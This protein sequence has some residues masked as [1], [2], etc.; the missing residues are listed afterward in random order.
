[1]GGA[2]SPGVLSRG[3]LDF[4]PLI[5]EFLVDGG[6]VIF[7]SV[8]WSG[9]LV[10]INHRVNF[11]GELLGLSEVIGTDI[12][13]GALGCEFW[14]FLG[15]FNSYFVVVGER[16]AMLNLFVDGFVDGDDPRGV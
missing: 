2:E 6:D 14:V 16:V 11:F 7:L 13:E 8:G 12:G 3:D 10:A 15:Y 1:M 4:Q 5:D 9:G